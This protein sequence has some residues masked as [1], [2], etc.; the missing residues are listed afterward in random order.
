M[1]T[2]SLLTTSIKRVLDL[3]YLICMLYIMESICMLLVGWAPRVI[4]LIITF[5][6]SMKFCSPNSAHKR[7]LG[8]LR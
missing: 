7:K 5:D 3:I 4:K 6:K 2:N 1:Y 8:Q